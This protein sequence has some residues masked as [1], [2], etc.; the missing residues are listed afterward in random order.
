VI[1]DVVIKNDIGLHLQMP[2]YV[3]MCVWMLTCPYI[4]SV[5]IVRGFEDDD[6]FHEIAE[7]GSSHVQDEVNPN[8]TVTLNPQP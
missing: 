3:C 6:G 5:K 1:I 8:I 2:L 7:D 4:G